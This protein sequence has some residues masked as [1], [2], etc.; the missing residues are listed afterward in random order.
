MVEIGG[1][2]PMPTYVLR[3]LSNDGRLLAR[4]E[5]QARNHSEA[6]E[7]I[8]RLNDEHAKELWCGGLKLR[9]WSPTPELA[10]GDKVASTV[11]H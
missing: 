5:L 1:R 11:W 7:R 4:A 8:D 10:A 3:L 2:G 6:V 9:S